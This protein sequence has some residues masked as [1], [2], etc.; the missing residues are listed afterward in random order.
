[1]K[2]LYIDMALGKVYIIMEFANAHEMF[3]TI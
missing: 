3:E 2:N 1:M